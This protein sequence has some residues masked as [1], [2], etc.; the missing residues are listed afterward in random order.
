MFRAL[1]AHLSRGLIFR[2]SYCNIAKAN[3]WRSSCYLSIWL[4]HCQDY[5]SVMASNLQLFHHRVS[6]TGLQ[7]HCLPLLPTVSHHA[8]PPSTLRH[9]RHQAGWILH[10]S[11]QH[12]CMF[13]QVWGPCDRVCSILAGGTEARG[14]GSNYPPQV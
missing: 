5:D 8:P 1:S 10:K 13:A 4:M 7:G 9:G 11:H 14:R 2:M 12:L 3:L 6:S